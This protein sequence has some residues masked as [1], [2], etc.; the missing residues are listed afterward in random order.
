MRD[1]EKGGNATKPM[2]IIYFKG[3]RKGLG[4]CKTNAY[5]IAHELEEMTYAKWVGKTITLIVRKV[6]AFGEVTKCVRVKVSARAY[7]K[8]KRKCANH[9]PWQGGPD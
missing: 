5:L 9:E 1:I 4:L 6:K 3:K 2:R 8:A 7:A